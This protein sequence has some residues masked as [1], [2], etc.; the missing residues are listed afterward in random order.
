MKKKIKI[1][2]LRIY[3]FLFLIFNYSREITIIIQLLLYKQSINYIS[4]AQLCLIVISLNL[5]FARNMYLLRNLGQ[6]R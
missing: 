6:N 1:R 4:F 3:I 2:F 5:S